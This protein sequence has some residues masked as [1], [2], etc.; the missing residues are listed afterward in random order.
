[1]TT[2]LAVCG[3]TGVS[4]IDVPRTEP[5]MI[6]GHTYMPP[7]GGTSARHRIV[8]LAQP[9]ED[10]RVQSADRCQD[11]RKS[12]RRPGQRADGDQCV[13]AVCATK[14]GPAAEGRPAKTFATEPEILDIPKD[15]P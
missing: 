12:A 14:A 9:G 3:N 2:S 4:P 6:G 7:R 13:T 11:L 15:M 10:P 8:V 5:L 1:M